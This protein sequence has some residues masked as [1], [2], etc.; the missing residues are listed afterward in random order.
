MR[1]ALG[2]LVMALALIG[3]TTSFAVAGEPDYLGL[4]T[5]NHQS[6]QTLA[7]C[8]G[9]SGLDVNGYCWANDNGGAP[10]ALGTKFTTSEAVLIRGVRI[11]R[12]DGGSV[13]GSLWNAAGG[14]LLATG[15]FASQ[16]AHGWQDLIFASPV[17]M[18]P[19]DTFVASYW[20]QD[21]YAYD[22]LYFANSPLTVGPISAVQS[23]T[24]GTYCFSAANCYPGSSIGANYWV[25]PIWVSAYDF[26]GFYQPVDN[27]ALNVA[28]AGSAIPVKFS[29]GGD[30]GLDIFRT[31]YPKAVPMACPG[32]DT[33]TDIIEQTMTAG[34]SSLSY[35][36]ATGEYTYVWKT[37]K[38][39]AGKCYQFDLGLDDLSSYAF[40]VQFKK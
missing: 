33:P 35:D 9:F 7:E 5:T 40:D 30:Q 28:K 29:L 3:G 12:V 25:T 24:N 11:Y 22:Y 36:A 32:G 19:G 23:V 38:D 31:G 37:S 1:R 26:T 17:S 6:G 15:N 14:T 13:S 20:V 21:A 34:N 8:G 27:E 4:W 10:V 2:T 16:T 18:V 39:W